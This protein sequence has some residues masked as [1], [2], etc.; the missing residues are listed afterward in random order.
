MN[1]YHLAGWVLFSL[2]FVVFN[3]LAWLYPFKDTYSKKVMR[4]S[5]VLFLSAISIFAGMYLVNL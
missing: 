4:R 5:S 1:Y 3:M 2:P